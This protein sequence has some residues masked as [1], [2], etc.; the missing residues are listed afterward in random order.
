[1]TAAQKG[2]AL[3]HN[4]SYMS[5]AQGL[6]A[7]DQGAPTA[8]GESGRGILRDSMPGR[9]KWWHRS[10][11]AFPRKSLALLGEEPAP[12]AVASACR[13]CCTQVRART[14]CLRVCSR[15]ERGRIGDGLRR[16][17]DF[18]LWFMSRE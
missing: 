7:D 12:P 9:E 3:T 6:G 15:S 18:G 16:E 8:A 11:R 2:A 4:S 5:W 1:V 13:V 10:V 17:G 14:V